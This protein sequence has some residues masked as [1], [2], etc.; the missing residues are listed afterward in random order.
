MSA[1][2]CCL[3]AS[4][5]PKADP[6]NVCSQAMRLFQILTYDPGAFAA[7]SYEPDGLR[8]GIHLPPT[9]RT[10]RLAELERAG[11][12]WNTEVN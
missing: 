9:A 2:R 10:G 5:Q 7:L 1:S 11:V 4:F 8:C 12:P 6:A 3:N